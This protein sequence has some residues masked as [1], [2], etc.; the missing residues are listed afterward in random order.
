MYPV[1]GEVLKSRYEIKDV[2]GE[3]GMGAVAKGWDRNLNRYVDREHQ[4][5][6]LHLVWDVPLPR[7]HENLFDEQGNARK[8]RS[9]GKGD[10]IGGFAGATADAFTL[11]ERIP[12][13]IR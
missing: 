10:V 3:G 1:S 13:G 4:R 5:V 8:V 2:L 12:T 6:G 7:R 9:L 11:F